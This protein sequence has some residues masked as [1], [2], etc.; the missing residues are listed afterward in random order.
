[1]ALS[2][3]VW[4]S[5]VSLMVLCGFSV[6]VQAVGCSCFFLIF[7]SCLI[8]GYRGI[9]WLSHFI[10]LA[11]LGGLIVIFLY[12]LSLAPSPQFSS[13]WDLL[14][15]PFLFLLSLSLV[16]GGV[17]F[18]CQADQYWFNTC[19]GYPHVRAFMGYHINVGSSWAG[20]VG[21]VFLA[22]VLAICMVRVTKLCSYK[23]GALRG[24]YEGGRLYA[25]V[26]S[27]GDGVSPPLIYDKVSPT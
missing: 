3:I 21:F 25:S 2:G 27:T 7:L 1:M 9:V 14:F 23:G 12:V 15:L 16:L 6:N 18:I 26:L 22:L 11:F 10:F 13:L 24:A 4:F 8:L 20:D 5:L 17:S 19:R